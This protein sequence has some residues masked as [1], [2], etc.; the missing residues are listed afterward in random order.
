[1]S[2]I[3][4]FCVAIVLAA[5]LAAVLCATEGERFSFSNITYPPGGEFVTYG[6]TPSKLEQARKASMI[7][8]VNAASS[9]QPDPSSSFPFAY[10]PAPPP[11]RYNAPT[12][13][14]DPGM[15]SSGGY[16][17]DRDISAPQ[18][19]FVGSRADNILM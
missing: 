9:S 4:K 2:H 11:L 6:A 7:A 16:K 18:V 5:I 12:K 17:M 1:M 15:F 3:A 8:A 10:S 19:G 14:L 13:K